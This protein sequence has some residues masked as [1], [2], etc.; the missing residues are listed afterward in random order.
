MPRDPRRRIAEGIYRG[1]FSI[2]GCVKVGSGKRAL[3]REQC[4]PFGT[5]TK[6][7]QRWRERTINELRE[8]VPELIRGTLN[9]DIETYLKRMKKKPASWPA[10]QSE[11]RA[12]AVKFGKKRRHLI[13][14]EM[15]DLQIAAWLNDDVSK[16]TILNRCRT[17]AH[18]YRTLANNKRART[19]LDT[20]DIPK[21]EKKAP[22][23]VSIDVIT[24]VEKKLREG[25]QKIRARFMVQAAT[26]IRPAQLTRVEKT[27]VDLERGIVAIDAAKGG[28]PIVHVL[29]DDM[30]AAWAIFD[31]VDAYGDY[32]RKDFATAVKEAGWPSGV[33]IYNT[34]HTFGMALADEDVD[35]KDV[36]DWFGHTDAKTTS[37]YTGRR[38]KRMQRVSEK[39]AGRLGWKDL[40]FT[41]ST[42]PSS[43][44]YKGSQV[45]KTGG[46][47][48][49]RKSA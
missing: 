4:F 49:R 39:M 38:I 16:K 9:A 43:V 27:H 37:I 6:E 32:N 35:N 40:T 20:I 31:S 46:N 19:P 2:S 21:P 5:T 28:N 26:G 14:P 48:R 24:R 8:D 10:K 15:V 18:L 29:S 33:R 34:K 30:Q 7:I 13:T 1:K 12:W 22:I 44:D 41:P 45:A 47:T 42:T 25:D 11:L 3:T 36:Q 23:G 17:F